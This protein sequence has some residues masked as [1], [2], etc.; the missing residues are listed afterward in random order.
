MSRNQNG[1]S[2]VE[3]FLAIT[4]ICLLCFAG[5]FVLSKNHDSNASQSDSTA[6]SQTE[7]QDDQPKG[8][9]LITIMLRSK[10][11]NKPIRGVKV[12]VHSDNGVRCIK[13]PCPTNGKDWD[14]TSD[15]NGAVAVPRENIQ[16]TT[17]VAPEGYKAA[18]LTYD[19]S[20]A[21]YD[22]TFEP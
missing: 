14:G 4:T 9:Q 5:W 21:S 17:N 16:S 3:G 6:S 1:F 11:S 19:S 13:A 12:K 8:S 18:Y 10:A 7:K 2:I 15:Q 20:K 22:M